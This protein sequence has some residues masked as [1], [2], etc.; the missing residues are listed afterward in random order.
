[1]KPRC[2]LPEFK[3]LAKPKP[4][5]SKT[6]YSIAGISPRTAR[7]LHR[8]YVRAMTS[9]PV[10][11]PDD[12]KKIAKE[13]TISINKVLESTFYRKAAPYAAQTTF[14]CSLN[15]LAE[16]KGITATSVADPDKENIQINNTGNVERDNARLGRL[17][18]LGK[19]S[20]CLLA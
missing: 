13:A 6:N 3:K 7:A 8:N 2:L 11:L 15:R 17:V 14:F 1:M 4:T 12:I 16:F 19:K 9:K 10:A 20:W 18:S 5:I